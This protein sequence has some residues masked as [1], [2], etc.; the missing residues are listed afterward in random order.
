M[1]VNREG[2]FH[3]YICAIGVDETGPNNLATCTAQFHIFEELVAD[4]WRDCSGEAL[5]IT[6]Y[7]YLEK[8]DGSL[9]TNTI[10]S[11]KAALG[12][13]GRDP[14]WLQD[15][16]LG[17]TAVQLKLGFE[18]YHGRQRIKVRFLNPY[19][20]E[21]AG[22]SKADDAARRSIGNRL[23]SKFRA[24]AGGTPA[25]APKPA[26]K[27][28]SPARPA[29]PQAAAPQA[30]A[31]AKRLEPAT[32]DE[33]WA[34]FCKHCSGA[35]WTA[36]AVEAEWFRIIAE[37]FPGRQPGELTEADWG[38]MLAEGPGRILPF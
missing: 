30:P 25:N 5:E 38:V 20:S 34:E 12:W 1:L 7:F 11:L 29:P 37:L 22:V 26:G 6:G 32:M 24:H 4:E 16:D 15:A 13:D 8:K 33:A 36:E 23:G 21:A 18:E 14:F 19:G 35:K 28:Q 3:A 27:P 9:N 2:L 31:A 17:E 10:E